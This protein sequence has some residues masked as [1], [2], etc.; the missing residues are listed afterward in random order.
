MNARRS[1][2][3]GHAYGVNLLDAMATIISAEMFTFQ[4]LMDYSA[5]R[6][7]GSELFWKMLWAYDNALSILRTAP[8]VFRRYR[9]LAARGH[10]SIVSSIS[11]PQP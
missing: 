2:Y 1:L 4:L 11:G 7:F 10:S 3:C 5:V 9:C 6:R 8:G